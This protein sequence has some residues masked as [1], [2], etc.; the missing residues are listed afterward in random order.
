MPCLT[1]SAI[2]SQMT[3]ASLLSNREFIARTRKPRF[4]SSRAAR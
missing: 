1:S 3:D 2:T 4:E